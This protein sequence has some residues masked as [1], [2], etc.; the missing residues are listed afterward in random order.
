MEATNIEFDYP[1]Y[2][3]QQGPGFAALV[4]NIPGKGPQRIALVFT[5]QGSADEFTKVKA[6][7][8]VVKELADA[9]QLEA[10]LNGL[11]KHMQFV[12]LNPKGGQS[13]FNIEVKALLAA[14]RS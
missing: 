2:T 7:G 8:A 4:G 10:F 9:D 6:R 11:P 14:A 12:S 13:P 1:I 3:L 5:D